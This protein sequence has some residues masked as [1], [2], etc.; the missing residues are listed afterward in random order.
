M[1]LVSETTPGFGPG[2]AV[3]LWKKAMSLLELFQPT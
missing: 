1:S 2:M 3:P